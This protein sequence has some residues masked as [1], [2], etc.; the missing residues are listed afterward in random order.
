[1]REQDN[2]AVFISDGS[3]IPCYVG[4]N[5]KDN[6]LLECEYQVFFE[7]LTAEKYGSYFQT[8]CIH[9]RNQ[10]FLR[11]LTAF[12]VIKFILMKAAMPMHEFPYSGVGESIF[13][14]Q[15]LNL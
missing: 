5:L 13:R 10:H 4:E 8:A 2:L 3:T 7:I 15:I 11:E 6:H 12:E 14:F 9:E 1:M